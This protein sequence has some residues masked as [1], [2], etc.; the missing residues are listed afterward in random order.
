MGTAKRNERVGRRW[1]AQDPG[2]ERQGHHGASVSRADR[3]RVLAGYLSAQRQSD[4]CQSLWLKSNRA[5]YTNGRR[6]RRFAWR[7]L[8]QSYLL[9]NFSAMLPMTGSLNSNP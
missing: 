4:F 5:E 9:A 2:P 7:P 3:S 1:R 8:N 6:R